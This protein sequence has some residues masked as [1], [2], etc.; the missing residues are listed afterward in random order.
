MASEDSD[1]IVP[2]FTPIHRLDDLDD[3]QQTTPGQMVTAGHELNAMSELL[4]VEPLGRPERILPKERNDPLEKIV[5]T[6]NN[7]AV[8]VLPVVIR[9]PVDVHLSHSKEITQLVQT[10][11]AL[12]TLCHDEVV[13]DLVS[14]PVASSTRST[15]LSNEPDREASFSVYKTNHPATELAQPFLLVFRTC[16]VVTLDIAPDAIE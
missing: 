13:R 7:V 8:E 1:E 10:R 11:D 6:T 15:G 3:L 9:P 14:G 5:S 16:H 12:G 4:K 2:G